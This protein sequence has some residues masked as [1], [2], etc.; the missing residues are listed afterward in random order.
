MAKSSDVNDF[1]AVFQGAAQM[2]NVSVIGLRGIMHYLIINSV[3]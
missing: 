2:H 1:A 3:S